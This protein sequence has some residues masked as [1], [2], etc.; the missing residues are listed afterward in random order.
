MVIAIIGPD[1][2]GKTTILSRLIPHF[3][4][5]HSVEMITMGWP[6]PT[7]STRSA[8]LILLSVRKFVSLI[9]GEASPIG[10]ESD[11]PHIQSLLD[12]LVAMERRTLALRSHKKSRLGSVLF[13]DRYSCPVPGSASGP[14]PHPRASGR[15][16]HLIYKY[17]CKVYESI[18]R[19]HLVIRTKVPAAIALSRN[20]S[21]ASPK[22]DAVILA[23]QIA[24]DRL[25]FPDV[26]EV[27]VDATMSV[28]EIVSNL[29]GKIELRLERFRETEVDH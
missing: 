1:A 10:R 25:R 13:S 17:E 26:P 11:Y 16:C 23:S 18:P 20:A 2:S 22:P 15:F 21:R 7:W 3:S 28:Q 24:A 27:Q 14:N 9:G 6:P 8:R 12:L 29:I 19:P 4:R 5:D